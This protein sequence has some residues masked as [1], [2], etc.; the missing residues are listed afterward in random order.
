MTNPG[1]A[2]GT[3]GA[4]G[5]RTS[6]NAFNDV[7]SVFNGRGILNGWKAVPGGDMVVN[8]GGSALVRDVAI[9]ENDLGQLTTLDNISTQPVPVL[10]DAA[11]TLGSRI[12]VIVGYVNNPPDAAQTNPIQ[13][14][15][16]SVCGLIAVQSNVSNTPAVPTEEMIR[17]AITADGGAGTTAYY[18]V[19]ATVEIATGV[20]TITP[21]AITQGPMVNIG[22]ATLADG[23]VTTQKLANG[24]VTG[25]KISSQTVTSGNIDWATFDKLIS[26]VDDISNF[27]G[28]SAQGGVRTLFVNGPFTGTLDGKLYTSTQ[29]RAYIMS[30]GRETTTFG[31]IMFITYMGP[32]IDLRGTFTRLCHGG[33]DSGWRKI[34]T[35]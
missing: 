32:S 20:T 25:D 29:A 16:P 8:L 2:V 28:P 19:L 22:S 12:D 5:G 33:F 7:L 31:A 3:N 9:V 13:I 11:P 23:S 14:D 30:I 35:S 17:A 1:D 27:S 6:V 4:Y 18:V 26:N 24:A 34:V 10:L 21:N 15:N